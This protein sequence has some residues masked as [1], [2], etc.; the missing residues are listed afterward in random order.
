MVMEV[1][2][3]FVAM[4]TLRVP[5]GGCS[6][7]TFCSDVLSE[8]CRPMRYSAPPVASRIAGFDEH[9]SCSLEISAK[10]GMNTK[11]A[12]GSIDTHTCSMS[13]AA[14]S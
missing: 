1:S 11:I 6:K 7:M 13:F 14:R 2:A 12:P 10:P 4:T 5:K 8:L 9:A 3:M